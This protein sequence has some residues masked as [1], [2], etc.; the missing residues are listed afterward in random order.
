MAKIGLIGCGFM[1]NMHSACYKALGVKVHSVADLRT[2]KSKKVANNFDSVIFGDA[3][4]LIENAR[5]DTV[6][7]C[8]PTYLHAEYAIM[9]MQHGKNVFIEKPVCLN[10]DDAKKLLKVQEETGAKV[11]I[12]QVIRLWNEYV[13]LKNVADKG[14][15][16]KILSATFRRLSAE[17][18]WAWNGWLHDVE[19][20][21]SSSL[22]MHIHDVD[23]IRYLMGEPEDLISIAQCKKNGAI[24]HIFTSYRFKNSVAHTEC[25]WD[26]PEEFPFKG[27][28]IVRFEKATASY[29]N[30]ILTV[31]KYG[32]KS[33]IPEIKKQ[34]IGKLTGG[35]ISDLGGYYNE[36]KYFVNCLDSNKDIE[37][38]TLSESVKSLDLVLNEI[39]SAIRVYR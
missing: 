7:I 32:E 8:L 37:I 33:F 16:G 19:K 34:D 14:I 18:A 6:D 10:M 35:N 1:G 4:S 2:E 26:H 9:A 29:E 25:S 3:K 39:N 11:M 27:E 31:Y 12:G 24:D 5:I 30:G 23:Y 22:D 20:S 36:L 17:P 21:G 38:S 28:F 13:Y 15:Y